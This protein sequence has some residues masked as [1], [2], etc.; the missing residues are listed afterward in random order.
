MPPELQMVAGAPVVMFRH[1][2]DVKAAEFAPNPTSRWWLRYDV[3]CRASGL[4]PPSTLFHVAPST[5]VLETP[6]CHLPRRSVRNRKQIKQGVRAHV[7]VCL[8]RHVRCT[9]ASLSVQHK[10]RFIRR[11]AAVS[12]C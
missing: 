8:C 4:E 7:H 10:P 5:V 3:L 11:I 6:I 2:I 1:N 12:I 9:W